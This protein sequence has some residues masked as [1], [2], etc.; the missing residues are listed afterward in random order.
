MEAYTNE[1]PVLEGGEEWAAWS[2]ERPKVDAC[3]PEYFNRKTE[4]IELPVG[5]AWMYIT[6][7]ELAQSEEVHCVKTCW[8]DT[9][10]DV[11]YATQI[12][13]KNKP[14]DSTH[15]KKSGVYS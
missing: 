12:I 2:A 15:T 9:S 10:I 4:N 8:L 14:F 13:E 6:A 5:F 3:G 1:T 11:R 7:G